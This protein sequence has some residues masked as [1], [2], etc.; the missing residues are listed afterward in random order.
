MNTKELV[1]EAVRDLPDDASVE[2]AME[3]LLLLAKVERGIEQADA[4]KTISHEEMRQR[5][6]KWLK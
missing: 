2:A 3:R 4:G 6:A 1:L 5:M